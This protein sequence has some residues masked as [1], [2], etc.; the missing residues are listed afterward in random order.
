MYATYKPQP[1]NFV[2]DILQCQ[3]WD[4]QIEI[5][6]D[7]FNYPAVA[8]K[9]C[10]ASGKSY[11]SARIALAF[12][13]LHPGSIV[14]TTA[15]TWRQVKDVLWRELGAAYELSVVKLSKAE[16]SQTGLELAKDWFAVGLSTKD[17]EKFF[18]YHADDIL[19]IV[20]EASGVEEAIY[21]GVD[22]ITPN[23]NAHTL[24]I[25]NPTN[26]DGRF[27][28]SFGN[29]MVKQHT[30]SAFDTPNLTANGL[31]T[32]EALLA[33]FTPPNGVDVLQYVTDVQRGL[34]MPYPALISPLTVYRRYLE[35]GTDSPFWQSLI[36]GQFPTQSEFSLIPINLIQQSMEVTKSRAAGRK[37]GQEEVY[38]AFDGW[39]IPNGGLELGI[40]VARYGTD[41]TV[42]YPRRGGWVEE[43]MAWSK[44]NTQVTTDRILMSIIPTDPHTYLKVDD[45]GVGG[46]VT[47]ALFR[48]K[49][50]NN[51]A[52]DKPQW[53]FKV[54][55]IN[56]GQQ[57]LDPDKFTNMRAEMFWNLREQFM[58]KT[59]AIPDDPELAGELAGIRFELTNTGKIQIERKDK[60][61]QRN[62]GK[63]PDKA[64]ALALA[65]A[66]TNAGTF[67]VLTH[68]DR[69]E[70]FRPEPGIEYDE[71][72]ITAGL[73]GKTF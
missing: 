46:G 6:K 38:A 68:N 14:V 9:S 15:P 29:P 73:Y 39:V 31:T 26:P 55:G 22:A 65:F 40:D 53:N 72:P 43:A 30:I 67:E 33:M 44:E 57:A 41:R 49:A 24:Y 45:T 48:R 71:E 42:M 3:P 27:Y 21:I 4:K 32:L 58:A 1:E 50:D 36:M 25:G 34:K 8:V 7:V 51:D 52:G 54:Q 70:D 60:M 10:N 62:G 59:I 18:G 61:K 13:V 5:I 56:F 63:S 20:D 2:A 69:P 64:D 35:W 17:S 16:V 23:V 37:N 47:D 19:V 28:K 11:I 66:S 12:L